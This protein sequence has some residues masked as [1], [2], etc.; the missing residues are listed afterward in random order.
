MLQSAEIIDMANAMMRTAV[1]AILL[2]VLII[3]GMVEKVAVVVSL[4]ATYSTQ[5]YVGARLNITNV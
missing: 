4:S 5:F 2:S 3:V 1:I